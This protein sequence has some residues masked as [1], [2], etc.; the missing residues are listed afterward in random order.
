MLEIRLA[1]DLGAQ[2]CG[3]A[4]HGDR[5]V[6][7]VCDA[8]L[9][10][11]CIPPSAAEHVKAMTVGHI[12]ELQRGELAGNWKVDNNVVAFAHSFECDIERFNVTAALAIVQ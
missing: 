7:I 11:R 12:A 5:H 8:S 9:V 1:I 4:V 2:S 10:E 3:V 6:D